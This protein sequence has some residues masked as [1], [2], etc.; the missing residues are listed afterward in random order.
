MEIVTARLLLRDFDEGDRAAFLAYHSDPRFLAFYGPQEADPGHAGGLLETFRL[1]AEERPRSNY[2]LA[3]A[4]AREPQ[5]LVGC[6]GLRG[7]P[8]AGR[9][10]LGI[11]L[12]PEYWG[13]YGYAIEVT[14]ALLE[15]G[16]CAL[17]LREIRGLTVSANARVGR[18]ASWFG[19]VA[20]A[21][22]PGSAWM[23]GR[24]ARATEWRI[25]RESWEHARAGGWRGRSRG[26]RRRQVPRGPDAPGGRLDR[27]GKQPIV[28]AP[29]AG[30]LL[31]PGRGRPQRAR[32]GW[33]AR[34]DRRTSR[35]STSACAGCERTPGCLRTRQPRS[36]RGRR[37]AV[38][39]CRSES[40]WWPG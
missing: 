18:L 27:S 40:S 7:T 9:A 35:T 15:F 14:D 38:P 39:G 25:T 2:Q 23:L 37:S 4:Q 10:E 21:T 17:G 32:A 33:R 20:L 36:G 5:A 12:A 19:A 26:R 6:C 16:F 30:R 13:R 34:R 29:R 24:A 8:C 1:W 28:A 31:H 11:E 22:R 3:V